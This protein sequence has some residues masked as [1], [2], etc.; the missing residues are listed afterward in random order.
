MTTPSSPNTW[1]STSS[2]AGTEVQVFGDSND[3]LAQDNPYAYGF[4]VVDLM[5]PGGRRRGSHQ[6]DPQAQ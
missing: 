6:A 3:L 1:P 5:L 2:H 4:Y